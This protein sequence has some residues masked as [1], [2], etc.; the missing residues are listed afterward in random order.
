[1][2]IPN[3][4]YYESLVTSNPVVREAGINEKGIVMAPRG[5]GVGLPLGPHYPQ[6]LEPYVVDL[7]E[8]V[9]K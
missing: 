7:A 2:A 4:T 9:Q 3:C 8:S 5:P 1:M 6:E